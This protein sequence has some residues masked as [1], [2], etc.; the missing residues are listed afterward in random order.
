M[1]KHETSLYCKTMHYGKHPKLILQLYLINTPLTR[2]SNFCH[3]F[4]DHSYAAPKWCLNVW[5]SRSTE[6]LT[7][8]NTGCLCSAQ[9]GS[10]LHSQISSQ[11]QDQ[12]RLPRLFTVSLQQ[13]APQ[14]VRL[15]FQSMCGD[16]WQCS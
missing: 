1:T 4:S 7:R 15:L 6:T 12:S 10:D 11:E 16:P 14:L 5:R 3:R 2:K 9:D 8:P 13:L